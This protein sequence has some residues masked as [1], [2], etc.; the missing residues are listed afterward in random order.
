MCRIPRAHLA[1]LSGPPM[2]SS[3]TPGAEA[4]QTTVIFIVLLPTSARGPE[5]QKL[6]ELV[7]HKLLLFNKLF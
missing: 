3:A 6:L 1:L 4:P 5:T 2:R 7:Y